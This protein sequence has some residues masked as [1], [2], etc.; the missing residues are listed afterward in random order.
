[1]ADNTARNTEEQE[2][3]EVEVKVSPVAERAR[4]TFAK[5]HNRAGVPDFTQM[6][7]DSV[8]GLVAPAPRPGPAAPAQHGRRG[9]R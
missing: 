9:D 4:A 1:M 2:F 3:P 5:T 7:G 6:F 8:A